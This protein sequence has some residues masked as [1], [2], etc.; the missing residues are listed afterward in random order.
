MSLTCALCLWIIPALIICLAPLIF[1]Y[2]C[3]IKERTYNESLTIKQLFEEAKT[4]YTDELY[5][6][7][8][9]LGFMPAGGLFIVILLLSFLIYFCF[10]EYNININSYWSKIFFPIII[11]YKYISK[12]INKLCNYIGNIKIA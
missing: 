3:F 11:I 4:F 12:I 6:T 7:F 8:I 5:S 1:C 10:E 9:V 2:I